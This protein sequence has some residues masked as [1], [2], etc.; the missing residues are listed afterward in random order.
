MDHKI[1]A[2]TFPPQF[3]GRQRGQWST[4]SLP[5]LNPVEKTP[6]AAV[7][8]SVSFR[9]HSSIPL[10]IPQLQRAKG[11]E[12]EMGERWELGSKEFA[13]GVKGKP[14]RAGTDRDGGTPMG[15]T[16]GNNSEDVVTG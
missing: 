6:G 12:G 11:V 2:R 5:T 13:A 8:I 9:A 7:P 14:E 15:M 1:E 10:Q 3:S 4:S 16:R